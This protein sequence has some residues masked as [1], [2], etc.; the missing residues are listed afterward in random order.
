MIQIRSF[1]SYCEWVMRTY[2]ETFL[3]CS[4]PLHPASIHP[5]V[6]ILHIWDQRNC[7]VGFCCPHF[8]LEGLLQMFCFSVLHI[9]SS[10][11]GALTVKIHWFFPLHLFSVPLLKYS[12][13]YVTYFFF[14]F[15]HTSICS[16]YTT[17]ICVFYSLLY[18][19]LLEQIPAI[20]G[21]K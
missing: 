12:H 8:H 9:N 15:P 20:V 6:I 17:G 13:I 19:E 1:Q 2:L 16:I 5:S 11:E 7:G 18:L 10:T 14:L 21:A 3:S 4:L